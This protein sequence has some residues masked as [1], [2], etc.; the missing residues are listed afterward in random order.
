MNKSSSFSTFDYPGLYQTANRTS[1]EAQN[2]YMFG[3]GL[4]LFLLIAA[5]ICNVFL[6]DSNFFAIVVAIVFI[7]TLFISFLLLIKRYDKTWYNGRAVAE[8]V[9]TITWRFM[10]HAKPY[11]SPNYSKA[12]AVFINDLR[13]ILE[14]NRVLGQIF[15]LFDRIR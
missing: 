13:Q 11:Q 6:F 15:I 8:S 4:Y 2:Y 1:I 3:I 14:Q 5:S 10:M 9:K 12:K 7:A